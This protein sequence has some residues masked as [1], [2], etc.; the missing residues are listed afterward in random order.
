MA[1]Q[2]SYPGVYIEEFA[3]G[4][5]IQGVGTSTA[6]FIGPASDGSI[7]VPT[8]LTSWDAFKATF[9]DQPLTGFY[10]WYAVR[11]FFMNGG[12]VCYVVRASNG[13]YASAGIFTRDVANPK[14]NST[15]KLATA[16]ARQPGAAPTGTAATKIDVTTPGVA[17]TASVFVAN[18]TFKVDLPT[19][20][21]L[22]AV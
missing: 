22:Q 14:K 7:D 4:A 5:P 3:P 2:V 9:G 16:R 6:A 13:D 21:P 1:V 19:G 20:A 18:S 15:A 8:K 11:G 17:R 10:L 12:Q